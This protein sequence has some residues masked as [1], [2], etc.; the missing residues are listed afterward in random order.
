MHSVAHPASR[1]PRLV[2]SI[3]VAIALCGATALLGACTV[4]PFPSPQQPSPHRPVRMLPLHAEPDPVAGGRIVDAAGREVLLRGVNVN[5]LV[6]YWQYG[7]FPTTFPLTTA[8]AQRIAGIGWNT[9]R[10]LVSWSRVEP[11]PGRYDDAYLEQVRGAVQLL[12]RYGVYSVIDF[13]QDA[14][15]PTLA[16]R[17]GETCPAGQEPAFGWDGAPGWATLDGGAARC[18]IA[19]TRELSPAVRAAFTAFW[20]DRPGPDGVG[21]RTRYAAMVAHVAARFACEPAVASYDIMNEPNAFGTAEL[22]GLSDLYAA[23][24]S[25]VRAAEAKAGGFSHLVMFEPSILWSDTEFGVPPDFAHDDN[26]VFAP[27]IYRG[28]L[29]AGPVQRSDFERAR[30]DAATFGGAPVFVGEWGSGPERAE[31]PNDVYFHT[32]QQLQD[33]FHFSAALWTWRESCGDPHKAGDARAGRVPSVWGE[34]EVDCRTNAVVG[35]RDALIE[36]LTRAYVR[37]APGRLVTTSYD[38]ASGAYSVVG[39]DARKGEQMHVSYPTQLHTAETIAFAGLRH[40]RVQFEPS[41]GADISATATGGA[42]NLVVHP[43]SNTPTA[44][45]ALG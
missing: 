42:W 28:G 23:T 29:T 35:T 22:Q 1:H 10:L 16:A 6:D 3:A 40:V 34:F 13:H 8:D 45:T 14:W 39:R 24:V 5:A 36:Q 25:A 12:A 11:A 21:I 30:R 31:D 32:H 37:A 4:V 41:G 19:G 43:A 7:A 27:H 17:P 26:V 9:V 33:E 20:A 44:Q 38:P 2:R 18:E 15:G